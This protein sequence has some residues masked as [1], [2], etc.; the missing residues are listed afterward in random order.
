MQKNNREKR[1][2]LIEK[3]TALAVRGRGPDRLIEV[4]I[5]VGLWK[6]QWGGVEVTFKPLI[7]EGQLPE[8]GKR[9]QVDP[10]KTAKLIEGKST[11]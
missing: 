11:N 4:R 9:G 8:D 3:R 6:E 7:E 1:G 2:P 10:K 5:L